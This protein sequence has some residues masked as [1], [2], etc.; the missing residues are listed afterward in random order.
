V[1]GEMLLLEYILC[2]ILPINVRMS[3]HDSPVH[4]IT[5]DVVQEVV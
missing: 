2:Y 1:K 5:G 4:T 3:F